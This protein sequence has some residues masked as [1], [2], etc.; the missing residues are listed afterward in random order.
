MTLTELDHGSAGATAAAFYR[1]LDHDRLLR[2]ISAI[3]EGTFERFDNTV[4]LIYE[5]PDSADAAGERG[6]IALAVDRLSAADVATWLD[7]ASGQLADF[8]TLQPDGMRLR[9]PTNAA[10]QRAYWALRT[11]AAPGVPRPALI[12]TLR[13]GVQIEWH[14]R[15]VDV[16][17]EIAPDGTA[18][19]DVDDTLND[20]ASWTEARVLGVE[21]LH[22]V[23]ER[24]TQVAP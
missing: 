10:V 3:N 8:L 24:L 21:P 20:A 18:S 14:T 12:P 5:W 6:P 11:L 23:R 2:G 19:I 9:R 16:E 17:V 4:L 7:A 22:G 15:G 13:G 1:S